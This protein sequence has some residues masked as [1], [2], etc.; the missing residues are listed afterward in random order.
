M[1]AGVFC[2]LVEGTTVAGNVIGEDGAVAFG[3]FDST[4]EGNVELGAGLESAIVGSSIEGN[5]ITADDAVFVGLFEGTNVDGNVEV[6]EN[7]VAVLFEA[8]VDGSYTCNDCVFEDVVFS[9]VGGSVVIKGEQDGAFIIESA[10]G[11]NIEVTDSQSVLFQLLIVGT[12]VEGNVTYKDNQGPLVAVGNTIH[13]NLEVE[14]NALFTVDN[15]DEGLVD[16]VIADNA[17]GGNLVVKDNTEGAA[18]IADN[19]IEGNLTCDGNDPAPVGAG[20]AA[21]E[22]EGQCE[23]L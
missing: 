4:V 13:G 16:P 12:T 10:V 11:G 3:A 2:E 1:E 22:L 8:T 19:T 5:V 15:P 20:N 17:I 21:D 14:N 7:V 23:N 18:L 6:G 9:E